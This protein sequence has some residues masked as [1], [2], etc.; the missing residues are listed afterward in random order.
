[1]PERKDDVELV[2]SQPV[3]RNWKGIAI[4]VLVILIVCSI[5]VTAI[6]LLTPEQEITFIG[7]RM[8]FDQVFNGEFSTGKYSMKWLTDDEYVYR[9][10]DGNLLLHSASVGDTRLLMDN[11][12]FRRLNTGTYYVSP[13]TKYVLLAH[14][15]QQVWRHTRL[16][17]YSVYEVDT[18]ALKDVYIN[19]SDKEV[20][21]Q[22][23]G[24]APNEDAVAIVH[25]NDLYYKGDVWEDAGTIVR[26]TATGKPD[27]IYNGLPDWVYEE[28]ILSR[29]NAIWW[30]PNGK[31]LCYASFN[32]SEVS[33]FSFP[34]YGEEKDLY[35]TMKE[36]RYP[37]AG[38]KNP[39]FM[40]QVIDVNTPT[41]IVELKAPAE[42]MKLPEFYFSEVTFLDDSR[43]S[44]IFQNR[45]QNHSVFALC[46]ISSG[47]CNTHYTYKES[48]GWAQ[49]YSPPLFADDLKS[50]FYLLPQR[51]ASN[52]DFM[53]VTMLDM[54]GSNDVIPLTQGTFD[55]TSILGYNHENRLVFYLATSDNKLGA[56]WRHVWSVGT[57]T[58]VNPKTP[59]CLTCKLQDEC[60]YYSAY[61]S[62]DAS[63]YTL[64]CRGPGVPKWTLHSI[65]DKEP[66]KVLYNYTELQQS[67]EQTALPKKIYFEVPI[68]N[69]VVNA[70]MYLPVEYKETEVVQYPMLVDVG[71]KFYGG[72]GS[73]K[74]L[75][76]FSVG[77]SSYL[78]SSLGVIVVSIDGRGSNGRGNTVLYE[79]YRQ[80][81]VKEVE[82]QLL[83]AKF[84]S[85]N[86]NFVDPSKMAIWGWSYGGFA[87]LR[88]LS[89]DL[90]KGGS[91]YKC[92]M[93][94]APVTSYRLYDSVYTERY[95]GLP[96]PTD[97]Y[98]MYEATTVMSKI[99]NFE[100][101][102]FLLIHGEAD[103]N[104]H[105]QNSAILMKDLQD[106]EIQ[107]KAMIYP[108]QNHNIPRTSKHLYRM[109][110]NYLLDCFANEQ[111]LSTDGSATVA[112]TPKK[113]KA[114]L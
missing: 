9:D 24:W 39:T 54:S 82:D 43:L 69:Y 109:L 86:Y 95:M 33:M 83:A 110:T 14:E 38:E 49:V 106:N 11:S 85:E 28:E 51:D 25:N 53:H 107:F 72:P 80:L 17:R 76:S 27:I 97:N 60:E 4:A 48:N 37:K 8:T 58:A 90:N 15:I 20:K 108:D 74:V 35:T 42:M 62:K 56:R 84:I 46:E 22:Y 104:V 75:D 87:T 100:A 102:D 105:Y 32:D 10:E 64:Y 92:G 67:V 68:K 30:S 114:R 113:M 50:F 7:D 45:H 29:D 3:D 47:D 91:I 52:G 1:M 101:V 96:E 89:H 111:Q 93:A 94:V 65:K 55:V 16:Q 57:P 41:D 79:V 18:G 2:G 63:Y 112:N 12:T 66:L 81:G 78:A 73:Q 6:V 36:L 44:V 77:W 34:W 5:I 99:E 98:A 103:D 19:P 40:L 59:V 70:Q 31:K 88:A 61:F 26:V 21:L 71:R 13:T 23:C